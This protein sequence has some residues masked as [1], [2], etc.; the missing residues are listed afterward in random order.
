[1][2]IFMNT[3]NILNKT[4]EGAKAIAEGMYAI[5]KHAFRPAITI[6]Y[7]EHKSVLP[8]R[9]MGRVALT[10]DNEGKLN[11][12]A[13]M[14]CT[15]VCPCGDLIQIKSLKD[16][17]NKPLIKTFTIDLGRCIFCGNC[18]QVCPKNAIV[19]T[20]MYELSTDSRKLLVHDM[21]MLKLTPEQS[22]VLIEQRKSDF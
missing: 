22:A 14:A 5:A 16:D 21:D 9:M 11:C 2:K 18:T 20:D 13:C 6:Q 12:I 1:M 10:V 15:K 3:Q 17:N 19:M 8:K 7:P 4:I